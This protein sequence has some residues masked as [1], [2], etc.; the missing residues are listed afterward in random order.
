MMPFRSFFVAPIL[1]CVLAAAALAQ[2]QHSSK[3]ASDPFQLRTGVSFAASPS[4]E[5]SPAA[6]TGAAPRIAN[7]I[8]DAEE[9][10]RRYHVFGRRLSAEKLTESALEGALGTLDPHSAFYNAAEWKELLDEEMSG[11]SGIGASIAS[12]TKDGITS[13]FILAAFK[14]SAA[15]RASL[16]YGDRILA[17]NGEDLSES[18]ATDVRNHLRGPDGTTLELTVERAVDG[19]VVTVA[20][21]RSI[22]PQ[23]SVPDAYMLRSGVGYIALTEGFTYTTADEFGAAFR[24]LKQQGMRSLVIDLRGNG[25]GIVDQSVKV[26]QTFLPAGAVIVTQRGRTKL[27]DRV[28]RS[29]NAAPE[30]LPVVLLVDGDTA[31]ASEIFAGAMQDR[32][33]AF[34]VGAKT[35]G[36]G[37]VQSVIELPYGTGLTLTSARYLTPSGRSIQRDYSHTGLYDYYNH[38]GQSA[39]IDQPHVEARTLGN[40]KVLGGDGILPDE[41]IDAKDLTDSQAALLDPIFF[42]VKD[43][44]NGRADDP[45]LSSTPFV[46]VAAPAQKLYAADRAALI[47]AF[48]KYLTKNR[49]SMPSDVELSANW[50]FIA[51]RIRYNLELSRKGTVAADRI[52]LE[53]D[54]VAAKGLELLPRAAEMARIAAVHK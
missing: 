9:L 31:S 6:E 35:F 44:V 10:I 42:F 12:Y 50:G 14:G 23:P 47:A 21:K 2:I 52:L 43:A 22:V 19:S 16:R 39:A 3:S 8:S 34:I 33:R 4:S 18:A 1:A 29:N 24:R 53:S 36:K 28:W 32:D 17:V 40:R 37:L 5:A 54:P 27:D 7:E 45:L 41:V 25:G 15:A 20:L 38:T 49:V 30:R 11:Y 48:S 51:D 26:A 13:T 46:S